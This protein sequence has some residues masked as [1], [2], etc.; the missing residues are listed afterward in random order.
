MN[1]E[2]IPAPLLPAPLL[3]V[4]Q[5]AMHFPI[6]EGILFNRKIGDVKAVDGIVS[7]ALQED[8]GTGDLTTDAVVSPK[9]KAYGDFVAKEDL[10]LAG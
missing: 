8:L 3:E 6:S 1:G 5:L 10:V 7:I 2:A 9:L 4:R